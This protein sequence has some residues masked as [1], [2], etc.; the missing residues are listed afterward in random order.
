MGRE[1]QFL[2]KLYQGKNRKNISIMYMFVIY[3]F[4]IY[5]YFPP[6]DQLLFIPLI[7]VSGVVYIC[8]IY[9]MGDEKM[10]RIEDTGFNNAKLQRFKKISKQA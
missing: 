4:Y 3:I 8:H 9:N 1:V 2:S 7:F 10:Y 5:V 6:S